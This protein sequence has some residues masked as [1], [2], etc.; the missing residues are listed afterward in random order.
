M[1]N[2]RRYLK[3]VNELCKIKNNQKNIF[4]IDDL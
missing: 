3:R 2:K 1:G 4:R